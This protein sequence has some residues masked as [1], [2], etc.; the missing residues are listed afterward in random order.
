[1]ALLQEL[2][3]TYNY[4]TDKIGKYELGKIPLA[5]VGHITTNAEIEITI[6]EQGNFI[7]ANKINNFEKILIP[8][9][10]KSAN[11]TGSKSYLFPHMLSDQLMYLG[12]NQNSYDEY[13]KQ[14]EEWKDSIYSNRLVEAIYSYVKSNT[15]V[16][17][18]KDYLQ[19]NEEE[20]IM[21]KEL[22]KCCVRWIVI[23]DGT[24]IKCWESLDLMEKY[25]N[26]YK[27][28]IQTDKNVCMISGEITNII[29]NSRHLKGAVP[30][31]GGNAKLISANDKDGFTFRG[32]FNSDN[33][34][35]TISY[36]NSIK[37]HNALK[38]LSDNQSISFGNRTFICWKPKG[39][40]L[41]L[42]P[43]DSFLGLNSTQKKASDYKNELYKT[44]IGYSKQFTQEKKDI[45]IVA[46][47][48]ATPGRLSISYYNE[49][50]ES[51][52]YQRL[53]FWD[54]TCYWW[55]FNFKEKDY[56]VFTPNLID[57]VKY[58]FGTYKQADDYKNL[59]VI[60]DDLYGLK[61]Q[62][63]IHCRVDKVKLPYNYVKL[64]LQKANNLSLFQDTIVK[65]QLLSITCAMINKYYFDIKGVKIEMNEIDQSKND[66][67]YHYGRLLAVVEKIERD[68]YDSTNLRTPYAIRMQ[69]NY[70]QHPLKTFAKISE[71]L[72][73]AYI[74]RLSKGSQIYYQN[75]IAEI[76]KSLSLC[77]NYSECA[78]KPLKE[79]YI[80]G[81]YLQRKD[82]YNKKNTEE[83]NK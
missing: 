69:A 58:T 18:I 19:I 62:E 80:I 35:V 60:K 39:I 49:L 24:P 45:V 23:V 25:S 66:I 52:Y 6:D 74:P 7:S 44:L 31:R 43:F 71:Q 68:T 36:L 12:I 8:V 29:D 16:K 3:Q 38:W 26:Y 46:F 15:I 76:M 2:I 56:I 50:Q 67:S 70:L 54:D 37:A 51:D 34:A 63:L 64:L 17:D 53:Q 73:R 55:N 27:S 77:D 78:D 57:I 42:N 10:E 61:M 14:I 82:L 20:K 22:G 5:P 41:M 4:S 59:F 40:N 33:E 81:Y 83:I 75:L 32:R 13:L 11:R 30:Q 9:T 21:G 28:K 72:N 79:T 48:A 47:G 1:M 65:E